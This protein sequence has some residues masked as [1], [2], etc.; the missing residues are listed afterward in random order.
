MTGPRAIVPPD[1]FIAHGL[2]LVPGAPLPSLINHGGPVLGSAQVVAIYWGA[3]WASG[4]NATLAS[5]LDQFFDFIL[6]SQYMDLLSEY[7]TATTPIRHGQRIQS[8][9]VTSNEP[10]SVTPAGRQVTDVQIQQAVQGWVASGTVHATNANTLYFVY[11]PPNVVSTMQNGSQSCVQYCGYHG[12]VG[13]V[14]YA[15][16]PYATC[17]GCVFPGNFLDTLT[18]VSSHELAEAI[19]D[20]ALNAWWD[21]ST[22]NEIGDICNRQTVRLGG[23]LIQTEWSNSQSACVIAPKSAGGGWSG[24][25]SLGGSA[26]QIAVGQN[27]DGR[28]E[29]FYVGTNNA[30][31]HN[32]QTSAGGGWSGENSIGGSA[33]Q[34]ADGQN[35]DG[36]LEVFYVGTN[37]AIYHNWQKSAGGGWNGENSLGGSAKQIAVGQNSDGRLEVFYVGTNDAIYHN[38][39]KSAGGGWNG[40]SSLGGSAKQIVV[41]QNKDGRLEV[42]YVGT[43]NALYHNWQTS[44][45]GGWNG[46]NS[47]GGSAK[48]VAVSQN[49][50]GRLE[51]F[52]VGTNDALYHNWQ[53]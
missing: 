18:E 51:L 14:Y 52:Y 12:A 48:Q 25:N 13:N 19:T 40:E 22:Q 27:K 3:S 24:E 37:D 5:Q 21:P 46:E 20:P 38:W 33:K 43:N 9:R 41:G 34:I 53:R 28:L 39:Q 47:L 16:I 10:G 30:L 45:G 2:S 31:Y 17:N 32:W 23:Y 6:T 4:A 44:A 26:K 36:R 42:F 29:L 1:S 49:R 35:S 11:L 50:D 7:S 15:V 8:V